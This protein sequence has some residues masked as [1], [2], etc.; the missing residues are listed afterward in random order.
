M[1]SRKE[2][3]NIAGEM[4]KNSF[5]INTL[6]SVKERLCTAERLD[7]DKLTVHF[8]LFD[9]KMDEDKENYPETIFTAMVNLRNGTSVVVFAKDD[10]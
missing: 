5:D 1:I 6:I 4:F 2:G 9:E 8:G 10:M 3:K 7:G